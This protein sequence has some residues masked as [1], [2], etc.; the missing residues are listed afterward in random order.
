[1]IGPMLASFA[2]RMSARSG[3]ITPDSGK[4]D[5]S[6]LAQNLDV[7]SH[8]SSETGTSNTTVFTTPFR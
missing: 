6:I 1:V 4:R 2:I 3:V 8:F 7:R 5:Y